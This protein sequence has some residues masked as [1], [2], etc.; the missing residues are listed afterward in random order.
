M[1][2]IVTYLWNE[3][4]R[5]YRAAHVNVLA[6]MFARHLTIPH[7]VVCITDAK[8]GFDEAVTVIETPESARKLMHIKTPEGSR[9]PSCYRRLWTFS[10]EAKALGK[11]ILLVDIDI[12]VCGDMRP[13]VERTEDFVGW[14]PMRDWG[15]STRIG[16]G[17][18]LLRAGSRPDV[19][20]DFDGPGAIERARRAGFRG[21]DQAWI[22]YKLGG[23]EACWPKESGIYSIRDFEG[24]N[25]RNCPADARIVQLNGPRKPWDA[26]AQGWGWVARNWH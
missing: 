3:G 19:W 12:V 2:N 21:S 10:D 1:L 17:I 26:E 20:A 25:P 22:S 24:R 14:R 6:R 16:G 5:D 7:R 23:T 15:N 8:D 18:F 4:F 13:V 9:F 11:R